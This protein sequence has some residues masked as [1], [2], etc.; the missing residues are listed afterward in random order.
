MGKRLKMRYKNNK[1]CREGKRKRMDHNNDHNHEGIQQTKAGVAYHKFKLQLLE[2]MKGSVW[3]WVTTE[4]G[5]IANWDKATWV[6][7]TMLE[8]A[9]LDFWNSDNTTCVH[10][11]TLKPIV[12]P[13]EWDIKI[14]LLRCGPKIT[15]MLFVC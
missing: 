14:M 11:E 3:G 10:R 12:I 9:N 4:T 15:I 6:N 8:N 5:P 2:E 7:E 13:T 1:M